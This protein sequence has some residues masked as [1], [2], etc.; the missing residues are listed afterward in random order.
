M[1]RAM[2][3]SLCVASLYSLF[4]PKVDF[5]LEIRVESRTWLLVP[6][7][8][9]LGLGGEAFELLLGDAR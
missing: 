6:A 8:R 1:I 4:K 7:S 5:T 9:T 2:T 3:A